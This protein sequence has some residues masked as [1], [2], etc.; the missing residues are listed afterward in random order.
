M[1]HRKNTSLFWAAGGL[2][3]LPLQ[4]CQ[5]L[6]QPLT[7]A[8]QRCFSSPGAY[9]STCTSFFS[10]SQHS[11]EKLY[12]VTLCVGEVPLAPG[13]FLCESERN[14]GRMG[15]GGSISGSWVSLLGVIS[16]SCLSYCQKKTVD[17]LESS[18]PTVFH[19]WDSK[20]AGFFHM[21]V[22]CHSGESLPQ[23]G[24][25]MCLWKN[26]NVAVCTCPA[27]ICWG[28]IA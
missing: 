5:G 20:Q 13:P 14:G 4:S 3:F 22:F 19:S 7:K 21:D 10:S 16:P 23:P 17:S 8:S 11:A 12:P 24:P 2:S 18:S 1:S 27:Q 15:P 25:L 28:W 26:K 9:V 6:I